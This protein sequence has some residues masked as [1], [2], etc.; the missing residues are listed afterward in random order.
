MPYLI[1]W[2]GFLFLIMKLS[3]ILAYTND[4]AMN[5]IG[6]GWP[7]LV[8]ITFKTM[9][10]WNYFLIRHP[11]TWNIGHN[12]EREKGWIKCYHM[13]QSF[14][15]NQSMWIHIFLLTFFEGYVQN[16][17][18]PNSISHHLIWRLKLH[19]NYPILKA[20]LI[21]YKIYWNSSF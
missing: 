15:K 10:K 16:L 9:C 14:M 21:V 8:S 17:Q 4:R 2:E 7:L 11:Q 5:C 6:H 12:R 20:Y 3:P 1:G 19:P 13:G 18:V